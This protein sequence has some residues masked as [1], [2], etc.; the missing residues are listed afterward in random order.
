LKF[1]EASETNSQ[2]EPTQVIQCMLKSPF[3]YMLDVESEWQATLKDILLLQSIQAWKSRM[4]G[5]IEDDLYWT[6]SMIMYML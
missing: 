3:M 4:A 1:Q 2:F 5:Y 6:V